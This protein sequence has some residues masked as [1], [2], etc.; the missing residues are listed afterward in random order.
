MYLTPTKQTLSQ[1]C[2]F[3]SR[4]DAPSDGVSLVEDTDWTYEVYRAASGFDLYRD[5]VSCFS[6]GLTPKSTASPIDRW[7]AVCTSTKFGCSSTTPVTGPHATGSVRVYRRADIT[8]I[9]SAPLAS[10]RN[11]ITEPFGNASFADRSLTGISGEVFLQSQRAVSS[12]GLV[13]GIG[14]LSSEKLSLTCDCLEP[15][16]PQHYL[17]T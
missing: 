16:A 8:L 2:S 13:R 5:A 11:A 4:P 10:S 3:I 7:S 9:D 17:N 12:K 6:R 15:W 1:R 14:L